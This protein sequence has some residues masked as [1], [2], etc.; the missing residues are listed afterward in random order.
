M[1]ACVRTHA[2]T[3]SCVCVCFTM[4][5][6]NVFI[7]KKKKKRF[8]ELFGSQLCLGLAMFLSLLSTQ[9]KELSFLVMII[10]TTL[11]MSAPCPPLTQRFEL[12]EVLSLWCQQLSISPTNAGCASVIPMV[13]VS[14]SVSACPP[15]PSTFRW[16]PP[17]L[18]WREASTG[19]WFHSPPLSWLYIL[20]F[21]SVIFVCVCLCASMHVCV[22]M[23]VCV[24]Q[25]M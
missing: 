5:Y 16:T 3:W 24:R 25:I 2:C 1:C 19:R 18:S 22:C 23:C 8:V 11:I 14:L 7:E 17:S 15:T 6:T 9:N 12:R 10:S 20:W 21:V 4:L 13:V